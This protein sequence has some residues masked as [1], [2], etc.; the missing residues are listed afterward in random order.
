[1]PERLVAMTTIATELDEQYALDPSTTDRYAQDG[2]I[3]LRGV[4]SR[5]FV[6][7]Y[8]PE[9]TGQV[10]SLNS[11]H[12]PLEERD[13]Y[14]RAFLQI[15]NL[16]EHSEKAR[17]FVFGKRLAGIAA[18]L[19][20]VRSVRL[21][22]DQALY[23]EAGG[24]ITPWHCDQHYWPLSTD[25]TITAWV[26]LQDTPAEMG[27]LAFATGSHR[28]DYGRELAIS[29]ESEERLERFVAESGFVVDDSPYAMGDVS[30]HSGWT[31]HRAPTNTT[32]TPR[33]VM[34][35]IYMD[36]EIAIA[37]PTNPQQ[38]VDWE[39]VLGSRPVG[40]P[41]DGPLNPILFEA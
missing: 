40:G 22:H 1:M 26:P 35:V 8:E 38:V 31:M 17:E 2:F 21:Y 41:A 33:R 15:N 24:G 18:Q 7:H 14:N 3:K 10:I 9:I 27:P 28:S 6:A 5:E 11:Q 34:T 37:Q 30:F 23:K 12:L 32:A 16:W 13:T 36:A 20:G 25:R 39:E 4:L 29:D 19:M